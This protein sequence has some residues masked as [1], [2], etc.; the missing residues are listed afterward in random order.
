MSYII[1]IKEH[2]EENDEINEEE[3]EH[4]ERIK[5]YMD[6]C[7]VYEQK[8]KKWLENRMNFISASDAG[9]VLKCN[10]HENYYNIILKKFEQQSPYKYDY[11]YNGNKYET[12]TTMIFEYLT[13]CRVLEY[14]FIP[15]YN[16][17]YRK[18]KIDKDI[19]FLGCSPD[20]II[21]QYKYDWIHKTDKFGEMLEIK[22][23][24]TR[25][26]N[27]DINAS[28]DEIF[29]DIPYYYQQV[30][31][32]LYCCDFNKCHFFQ[33]KIEEYKNRN[34]FIE[35]TDPNIPFKSKK[36]EFKGAVIQLLPIKK[37][38]GIS[39]KDPDNDLQQQIYANAKFIY[40]P[41]IDMSIDEILDWKNKVLNKFIPETNPNMPEEYN[42]RLLNS[43][44]IIP[45]Y[46]FHKIFF[47]K[48]T[49]GRD[50]LVH[51]DPNWLNINYNQ[52][53]LTWDRISFVKSSLFYENLF[54]IICNHYKPNNFYR[55]KLKDMIK[56]N[57]LRPDILENIPNI[58]LKSKMFNLINDIIIYELD[59]LILINYNPD[60]PDTT[61]INYILDTLNITKEQILN[62][63]SYIL[64]QYS[65]NSYNSS[66]PLNISL[67]D[68]IEISDTPIIFNSNN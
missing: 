57:S 43:Y 37:F 58:S 50:Q 40:P 23:P 47:W 10:S 2:K 26:I 68:D 55:N 34:E 14:G 60:N 39:L 33:L 65:D 22:N 11:V 17:E 35:D 13:D 20:G 45:G 29:K 59:K 64:N 24:A 41:K 42:E 62:F 38:K 5:E 61:P 28:Q 31:Q 8:S 18:E 56:N 6:N 1:D 52:Y 19:S 32:Q 36:G 3:F 51:I 44:K 21:S 67:F 27:M 7:P 48:A 30:Q 4:F 16:G 46:S 25:L 15:F 12:I 49:Y 9:C 54:K 53:K 63:N 66:K